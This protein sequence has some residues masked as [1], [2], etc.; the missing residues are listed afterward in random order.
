MLSLYV[1]VP[2]IIAIFI[3][4]R[5]AKSSTIVTKIKNKLMWSSVFRSQI[6][7]YFPTCLLTMTAFQALL[8]MDN[9][10][11]REMSKTQLASQSVKMFL[12]LS[13]PIFSYFFLRRNINN[14]AEDQF[15]VSYGTLY[16]NIKLGHKTAYMT[17]TLFCARR[18]L[19]AYGTIFTT[20]HILNIYII[21]FTCLF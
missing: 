8:L 13:L 4:G 2:S 14:L 18:L 9:D 7:T 1:L 21:V 15:S 5:V 16:T 19:V 12:L 3:I 11:I 20:T 17:T 6:Q 10:D